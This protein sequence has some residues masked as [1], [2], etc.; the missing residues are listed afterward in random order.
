MRGRQQTT[1][2]NAPKNAERMRLNKLKESSA[3]AADQAIEVVGGA[4]SKQQQWTLQKM[5]KGCV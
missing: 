4:V 2:M 1:A 3:A 5:L